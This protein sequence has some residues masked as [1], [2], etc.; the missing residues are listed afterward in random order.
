MGYESS[1]IDVLNIY[2]KQLQSPKVTCPS[3][4]NPWTYFLNSHNAVLKSIILNLMKRLKKIT[5]KANNGR[6]TNNGKKISDTYKAYNYVSPILNPMP[7]EQ[8]FSMTFI[9]PFSTSYQVELIIVSN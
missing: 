8:T 6:W 2:N 5:H 7:K 1:Y 4:L 9:Q 3:R